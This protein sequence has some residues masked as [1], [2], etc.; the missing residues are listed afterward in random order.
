MRL[1]PPLKSG[2][3]GTGRRIFAEGDH[4][5]MLGTRLF[6]RQRIE[7]VGAG[8]G[9]RKGL[10][11][12]PREDRMLAAHGRIFREKMIIRLNNRAFKMVSDYINHHLLQILFNN[13]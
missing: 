4:R 12:R 8:Q 13:T 5:G 6:A 7:P 11:K 10:G 2:L 9:L 1:V 3:A